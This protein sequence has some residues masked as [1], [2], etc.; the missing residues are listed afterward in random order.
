MKQTVWAISLS[1]TFRASST[2]RCAGSSIASP[3]EVSISTATV[4]SRDLQD[5][6]IPP[7]GDSTAFAGAWHLELTVVWCYKIGR[8]GQ[9]R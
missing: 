9:A 8:D 5:D 6:A 3:R 1:A 2:A 4:N 7:S